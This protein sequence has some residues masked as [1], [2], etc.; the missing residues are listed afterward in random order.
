MSFCWI[1]GFYYKK[2]QL[3]GSERL[4][5]LKISENKEL[6]EQ[7]MKQYPTVFVSFKELARWRQNAKMR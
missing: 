1:V 6:C 4:V 2:M 7:W 5:G 3:L